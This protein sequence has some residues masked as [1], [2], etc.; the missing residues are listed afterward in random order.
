M[1]ILLNPSGSELVNEDDADLDGPM[2]SFNIK[3]VS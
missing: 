3:E 1:Y 2:I